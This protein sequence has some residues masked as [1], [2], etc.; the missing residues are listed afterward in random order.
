MAAS[1]ALGRGEP[2]LWITGIR[3]SSSL[4]S[5]FLCERAISY[6]IG[7]N[8]TGFWLKEETDLTWQLWRSLR[9]ALQKH[10]PGKVISFMGPCYSSVIT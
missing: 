6:N 4:E 5:V 1:D 3:G 9:S 2:R 10:F 8:P 7:R